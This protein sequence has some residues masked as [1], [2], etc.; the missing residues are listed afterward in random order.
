MN[1][2]KR[3]SIMFLMFFS[4]MAYL[5]ILSSNYTINVTES[6]PLGIYKLTDIEHIEIGDTVQ[7]YLNE[8]ELEILYSRGYLPRF[9]K[10]LLKEVAADYSNRDE[11]EIKEDKFHKYLYVSG[12]NYGLIFN[13]DS[14]GRAIKEIC[15]EE[16]KPK[17]KNEYLLL[18]SHY[19]SYDSRYFGLISKD[20][21]LKKAEIKIKF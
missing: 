8:K 16:L 2:K 10:T 7:F 11:I 18:S 5:K 20:K 19:K 4:F 3:A 21:I 13:K 12:K 6:L 17:N 14:K 1:T 9:A 15:L